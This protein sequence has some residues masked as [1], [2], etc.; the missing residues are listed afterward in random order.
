MNKE[1]DDF[2]NNFLIKEYDD[3]IK[4]SERRLKILKILTYI[5][6]VLIGLALLS[7][8][9]TF[10]Y[11]FI[12]VLFVWLLSTMACYYSTKMNKSTRNMLYNEKWDLIKKHDYD[13]WVREMR[14]KKL[15]R[16]L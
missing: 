11:V 3:K 16:I 1:I 10:N 7:M 6:Y 4:S 8:I 5:N 14:R 2:L 13:T 9:V 12:G 15:N